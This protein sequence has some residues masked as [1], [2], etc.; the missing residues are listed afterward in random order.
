MSTSVLFSAPQ[1]KDLIL[2]E[3]YFIAPTRVE[4]VSQIS[5]LP[6]VIRHQSRSFQVRRFFRTCSAYDMFELVLSLNLLCVLSISADKLELHETLN[7]DSGSQCH[8][9]QV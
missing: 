8:Q 5:A 7:D 9:Q 1:T 6:S 2:Y 3:E 4:E